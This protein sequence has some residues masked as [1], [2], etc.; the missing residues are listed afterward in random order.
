MAE[1]DVSMTFELPDSA[2]PSV[3]IEIDRGDRPSAQSAGDGRA[4]PAGEGRA[5]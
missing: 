3:F 2:P 4:E 1:G 5:E